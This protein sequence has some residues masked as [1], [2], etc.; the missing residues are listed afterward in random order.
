[1]ET[2]QPMPAVPA[3]SAGVVALTRRPGPFLT[4]YLTTDAEIDNAQQRSE[5]RWKT[6]RADLAQ[7]GAPDERVAMIDPLVGDAHLHGQCLIVVIAG[8]GTVHVEHQPDV[9]KADLGRWGPLPVLAPLLEWHQ[10]TV[11]H[12]VALADRR[13]ADLLV[14]AH[15]DTVQVNE[16]G[17]SDD[18]ITKSAPG[19]W[20]QRRFQQRA[21][22][23]WEE[24][25]REVAAELTRLVD[26]AHARLV[27]VAGDVRAVQLL[28]DH[29]DHRID[30]LVH[31]IGGGR[32]A[33]G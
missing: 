13:G 12:V 3:V 20:S 30:E 32:S 33:D 31:E 16:V 9:P 6:I 1:M 27:A 15:D 4:V 29:L 7:Q 26:E 21:E 25:A 19:G 17:D 5:Q 24:N 10:Q 2:S 28:R 11:P 22:N 23:T 18:P 8:D 14:F